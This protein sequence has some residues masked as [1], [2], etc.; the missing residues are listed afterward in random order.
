[1]ST[2]LCP[3][4]VTDVSALRVW[5]L[6]KNPARYDAWMD[7]RTVAV[8]PPG[9]A[10]EGQIIEM[11]SRAAGL[12]WPLTLTVTLVDPA[13]FAIGFSGRFPAGITM[14]NR[15]ECAPISPNSCRVQY[16]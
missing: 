13:R 5:A 2:Q 16:G 6:L 8:E 3:S 14:R 9:E 4:A 12:W 10:I 11:R 7:A 1:M 15:I